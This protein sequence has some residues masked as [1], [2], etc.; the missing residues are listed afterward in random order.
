MYE[1]KN[2]PAEGMTLAFDF[3]M[4]IV[5]LFRKLQ[6]RDEDFVVPDQTNQSENKVQDQKLVTIPVVGAF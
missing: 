4:P 5:D 3:E 6:R 1:Y 2:H